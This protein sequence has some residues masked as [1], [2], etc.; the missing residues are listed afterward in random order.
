VQR[1]QNES[2]SY[3]RCDKRCDKRA[4]RVQS[5]DTFNHGKSLITSLSCVLIPHPSVRVSNPESLHVR[6]CVCIHANHI[7][8]ARLVWK[9]RWCHLG[10]SVSATDSADVAMHVSLECQ[11]CQDRG[12][13]D[14]CV[15]LDTN[16]VTNLR[17]P[18]FLCSGRGSC[19]GFHGCARHAHVYARTY[20]EGWRGNAICTTIPGT[21]VDCVPLDGNASGCRDARLLMSRSK[22][23]QSQRPVESKRHV[24]RP[25]LKPI[26]SSN[27]HIPIH[28]HL[29]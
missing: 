16:A 27:V 22:R 25:A 12:Y 19:S 24:M 3:P 23:I 8:L 29:L 7:S 14:P 15:P 5:I 20:V 21:N 11:R 1:Q 28:P 4:K 10:Q 26:Q 2:R 17:T 18:P 13:S 9:R 6:S